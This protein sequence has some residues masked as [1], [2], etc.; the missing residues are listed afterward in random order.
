MRFLILNILIIS[1]FYT[2]MAQ[3]KQDNHLVIP[4]YTNLYRAIIKNGDTIVL[5]K[6]PKV[7]I[8]PAPKLKTKAD[9]RRFWR[10]VYNVKKVYPYVKLI[11]YYYYETEE[12]MKYMDEKERKKYVKRM[13]KYLRQRF[14]K[15]LVNLTVRQGIILVRLVSRQ[16]GKTT[17]EII[18][19]FKGNFNAQF[20][21]TIAKF[22]GN[23]LQARYDP[24]NN[25][26]DRIIEYIIQQI[27]MGKF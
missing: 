4:E 16:T 23:D 3:P 10:L 27:E 5:Y 21:Q 18:K 19:D 13:E 22:F 25:E 8:M 1:V 24:F 15:Q 7:V 9:W 11:H 20:W 17:Y 12:A 2:L 26:E 6:L 14:E